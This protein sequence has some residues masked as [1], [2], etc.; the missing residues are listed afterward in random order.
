MFFSGAWKIA[1]V[2]GPAVLFG[3]LVYAQQ[4]PDG[5]SSNATCL[6]SF[7]WAINSLGQSPCLVSAWL[8]SVCNNGNWETNALLPGQIYL[9]PQQGAAFPCGCNTVVYS[10]VSACGACQNVSSPAF[11]NWTSWEE[12]CGQIAPFGTF[13]ENISPST[14]VPHWAY[15]NFTNPGFDVAQAQAAGDSPE[16]TS[17]PAATPTA[18]GSSGSP[19]TPSTPAPTGHKSNTGAIAGGVV[20]GIVGLVALAGLV[21]VILRRRQPQ[22][23]SARVVV[24][25]DRRGFDMD[26]GK[27]GLNM[28]HTGQATMTTLR[29]GAE[30]SDLGS[31]G[32]YNPEDPSTYPPSIS[33]G[34]SGVSG[35]T[36][37]TGHPTNSST[38]AIGSVP[39]GRYTGAAEISE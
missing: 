27:A 3:G 8:Q 13:P 20:G 39:Q 29:S 37:A 11:I 17:T 36:Y 25:A 32:F 38:G 10:L 16:S 23:S 34:F 14:A 24:S 5:V 7:S 19:S 35:S 4:P 22:N 12:N 31:G 28:T 2:A 9:G 18:P 30:Y 6:P 1:A 33:A 15:L 21:W 26:E